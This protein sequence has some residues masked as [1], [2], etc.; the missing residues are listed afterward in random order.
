MLT[1]KKYNNKRYS[2]KQVQ[3][4]AELMERHTYGDSIR[5]EHEQHL[6]LLIGDLDVDHLMGESVRPA[7]QETGGVRDIVYVHGMSYEVI[8]E[9]LGLS[10]G[11]IQQIERKAIRKLRHKYGI[12]TKKHLSCYA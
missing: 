9:K 3:Y 6:A 12:K 8:A 5:E 4:L 11:R 1:R 10:K 2:E 7:P